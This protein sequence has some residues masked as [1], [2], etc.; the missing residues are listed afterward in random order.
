M[1]QTCERETTKKVCGHEA[2]D[3]LYPATMKSRSAYEERQYPATTWVST[4]TEGPSL[5]DA[6]N[7]MYRKLF[8]YIQGNNAKGMKLN[9][10]TPI[11]TRIV[12]CHGA[13]CSTIFIMSFL[14]PADSGDSA[15]TPWIRRSSSRRTPGAI[16]GQNFRRPPQRVGLAGGIPQAGRVAEEGALHRQELLLHG[17]VRPALSALPSRQ[18]G[19]DGQEGGEAAAQHERG[20][21]PH[22]P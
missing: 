6:N 18:R 2:R 10:T 19:L 14:I 11:R 12:P 3:G 9:T 4:S 22:L 15:P 8:S 7:H 5:N 16:R 13:T 20:K 17:V 21:R 1:R